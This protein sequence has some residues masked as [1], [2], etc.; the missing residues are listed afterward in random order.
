MV[1]ETPEEISPTDLMR[2]REQSWS[3]KLSAVSLVAECPIDSEF[4]E[5]TLHVLGRI[6]RL[7]RPKGD[8]ESFLRRWPAV[9]VL[10]TVGVAADHYDH[11]AFWPALTEL[12]GVEKDQQF[13]REWGSAFLKNLERLGLPTFAGSDDAGT[14]YV[15]RILMHSGVPTYCL[16]DYYRLVDDR[17]R[18][19]PELDAE[20]F[21]SWAV[22]ARLPNIDKP[23]ARFLK[24]GG[25]FAVD[26]TDRVFELLDLVTV[27]GDPSSVPLPQRFLT[28]AK[29]LADNDE[30]TPR[31]RQ[32]KSGVSSAAEVRPAL[33]LDPYG[34]GV[35][36]RLPAVSEAPD[37]TATWLVSID[38]KS[39]QQ[40]RTKAL[41]PGSG[42]P[43]PQTDFSIT[44]PARTATAALEG[45]AHLQATV[46][47][48]DDKDPL[49]AF[50]EQ[51]RRLSPGLPWKGTD[52]WL[53]FPGSVE[54]LDAEGE[55]RVLSEAPLPPGWA[56]WSLILAD[57]SR[58]RSIVAGTASRRHTIQM[59]S[60]ARISV[61]EPVQGVRTR[62]GEA[63]FSALP[64][65]ELP[66]E[67]GAE[68]TWDVTVSDGRGE[69]LMH[70]SLSGDADTSGIWAE[71]PKPYFGT[72]SIR[73]R[74]PW[75]RGAARSLFVVEDLQVKCTPDWR[76]LGGAEG[77]VPASVE[78]SADPAVF[79]DRPSL[80]FGPQDTKASVTLTARNQ[81]TLLTIEPPHISL[82]YLAEDYMLGPSIRPL[83]LQ[84]ESVVESPGLLA[85]HVGAAA[86]PRLHVFVRGERVQE[87]NPLG[88]SR[89]GIYRF[90]LA[91]MADTLAVNPYLRLCLDPEGALEVA[92]TRPS[93][94]FSAV[95]IEESRI[96]LD[97]CVRTDG[98]T[99]VVYAKRAP[100][101]APVSIPITEGEAPLPPEMCEAG[102][103]LVHARVEDPWIP[104]P[105]PDWPDKATRA[106]ADGYLHS[107][108]AAET[109]LSGFLADELPLPEDD[110]DP[111]RA[112]AVLCR[113]YKLDLP[114]LRTVAVSL[115]ER[116][117]ATPAAA[118]QA[119]PRS[120]A[121]TE[122]LPTTLIRAGLG[123]VRTD[124]E[125]APEDLE[126]SRRS[127][128]TSMLLL[129]ELA[130]EQREEALE[131]AA[132]VCGDAV[133]QLAEG[134]DPVPT[135]GRF[136]ESADRYDALDPQTRAIFRAQA[137][138]VPKGL[139]D[140]DSRGAAAMRLLETRRDHDLGR[141]VP[142]AHRLLEEV[143]RLFGLIDAPAAAEA[144]RARTHPT[145]P[146]GWRALPAVSMG[147]ALAARYA[148]HGDT[149]A[150][151]WIDQERNAWAQLAAASP[152]LVTID[153]IIAELMVTHGWTRAQ[154][155]EG[156]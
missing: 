26:V 97:D 66:S 76:R 104:E 94:L 152:E 117:R 24:Y 72:L 113:S 21:V 119:L 28:A 54:T 134:R 22:D 10:S 46:P 30:L 127:V 41:W 57:L 60:S 19:H 123:A 55:L 35:L 85:L 153:M 58:V 121:E 106:P 105:V 101:R 115:S 3:H 98:L 45:H 108:D 9:Q 145:R 56:G 155:V 38:G 96:V 103:L 80:K 32:R 67:F 25:E 70:R 92:A 1:V 144:V 131:A 93:R 78:L 156:P 89:N 147:F 50:D 154:E 61:R 51:G 75:G 84:T 11:G 36:L 40:I 111:V 73:V 120:N 2:L 14:A 116:L 68:A 130:P 148:A 112:W 44:A 16:A 63:V 18:K 43:A 74:G 142:R 150:R 109:A 34:R 87:L 139:L 132:V 100:W 6:Y 95:H 137:A 149:M 86:E 12:A 99:A 107:A 138:F 37:G 81:P 135:A 133:F 49:L 48:V 122:V 69:V 77:L 125:V 23:V 88:D 59:F 39:Q 114:D 52:T 124:A 8:Q 5:Q 47:I 143:N 17:R 146:E 140:A 136:D 53:L 13:Q 71:L 7:R 90:N 128:L 79:I 83:A 141:V 118:L 33:H 129:R 62:T 31:S 151:G 64:K 91:Q 15:G 110:I 82:S 102:P 20:S 42:E 29:E 4:T 65:L 126:W 27:G